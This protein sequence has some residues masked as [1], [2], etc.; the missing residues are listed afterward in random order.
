MNKVA[1]L[2]GIAATIA[3]SG[4][5][6]AYAAYESDIVVHLP[7]GAQ[8]SITEFTDKLE[9]SDLG[10]GQLDKEEGVYSP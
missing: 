7:L 4:G 1:V 2:I 9:N 5:L 10:Y 3:V 8:D 6:V